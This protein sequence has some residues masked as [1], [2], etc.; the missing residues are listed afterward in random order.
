[1]V[2]SLLWGQSDLSGGVPSAKMRFFVFWGF[3][4]SEQEEGHGSWSEMR[5]GK[6]G[7]ELGKG[8]VTDGFRRP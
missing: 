8:Q 6:C 1:M 3:I 4:G 5:E 2:R 7:G